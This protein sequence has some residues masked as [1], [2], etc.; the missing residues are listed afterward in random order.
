[1]NRKYSPYNSKYMDKPLHWCPASEP[2]TGTDRLV[3][4]LMRGWRFADGLALREEV[5]REHGRTIVVY[6]F[7][8]VHEGRQVVM[9]IVNSPLLER[10][11]RNEGLRV[12]N[13]SRYDE[14]AETE[15]SLQAVR[16][17]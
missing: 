12:L 2:Y 16:S 13:C 8:L 15:P 14:Q 11:I 4:V 9:K 6:R 7:R 3:S 1:M 5:L 10:I 17:G